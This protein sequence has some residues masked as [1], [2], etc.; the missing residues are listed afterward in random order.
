MREINEADIRQVLHYFSFFHYPPSFT[1]IYTFLKKK[2]SKTRLVSILEKMV[3]K[4]SLTNLKSTNFLVKND[5]RYTLG[6]YSKGMKNEELKIKNWIVRERYSRNKIQKIQTFLKILFSFPQIKLVGL[7]GTVSMMNAQEKD[8]IDLF[9]ITAK[10]RLWT[11]RMISLVM[12]QLFGL[13]RKA[14][15][16]KARDKI[17][18]NLF[19]DES[20]LAISRYKQT[21]YVAHEV[22]QMKSLI[23][24][25]YTYE[26][27]LNK[28]KWVYDIFPNVKKPVF[29]K[30]NTKITNNFIGNFIEF[31]LKKLQLISIKLHQ[32]NE[33][34]TNTQL[35]FFPQDFEK[36]LKV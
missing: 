26:H 6:E 9:I 29:L 19:F 23:N 10:K 11:A 31:C 30:K 14:G 2:C 17:C 12:A 28:N 5:D 3:K 4:K 7:S 18:L 34:V 15:K 21:E 13:R 20:N 1:E 16:T 25:N 32:T 8:D 22:L 27:F 24:K 35:W 36:K 33:I